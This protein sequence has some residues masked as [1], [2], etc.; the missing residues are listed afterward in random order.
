MRL[1]KSAKARS[2]KKSGRTRSSRS[3]I[4]RTAIIP[5][6]TNEQIRAYEAASKSKR[7]K[8]WR[9]PNTSANSET[10]LGLTAL[11]ARSRDLVRNNGYANRA[12]NELTSDSIGTGILLKVTGEKES[13]RSKIQL[14]WEQWAETTDCDALG[15]HDIYG[16]QDLIM[17]AAFESGECLIR[18]RWRRSSDG[19][20]LPMQ[21]QVLESDYIDTIKNETLPHGGMIV[22]GIEFDQIGRRVAYWLFQQH[23]GESGYVTSFQSKRVPAEDIIPVYFVE[24]PGQVRGIPRGACVILRLRDIDEVQDANVML[25]KIAPCFT[26]FITEGEGPDLND[27]S[28]DEVDL[29][30]QVEPAA[31]TKLRPG[32]SVTHASPPQISGYADFSKINLHTV[33]VGYGVPYERLTGDYGDA[34]FSSSRMSWLSF[35]RSIERVRWLMFIPRVLRGGIFKWFLE[36]CELSGISTAGIGSAWTPPRR[37][38][39]DP[40]AETRALGEAVRLGLMSLSEAIR[41]LGYDPKEV[42]EEKKKDNELIDALGLVLDSDPRQVT[43]QGMVQQN[44]VNSGGSKK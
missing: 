32:Q 16:L 6:L 12:V 25:Q 19:L 29:P 22:Q 13:Q 1:K 26:I 42:L 41:Q 28:D 34:S 10:L 23:P 37:Q 8:N 24:R 4:S 20:S 30:A 35:D 14:K 18:R 9:T 36:A 33:A 43:A 17:K 44:I 5:L 31:I 27:D 21:L 38:M 39:I 11:R 2:P 3:A 40:V 15:L 7:T